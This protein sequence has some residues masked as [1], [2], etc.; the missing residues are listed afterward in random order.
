M[1]E[2]TYVRRIDGNACKVVTMRTENVGKNRQITNITE[3]FLSKAQVRAIKG[4]D[5]WK[6]TE[7]DPEPVKC[8][9]C[10][11]LINERYTYCD[12]CEEEIVLA[13]EE[14]DA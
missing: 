9:E 2:R 1:E 7:P 13:V 8:D 10:G 14:I 4:Y 11:C 3:V 12:Q 6:T 5:N